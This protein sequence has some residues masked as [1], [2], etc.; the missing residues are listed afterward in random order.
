MK[1]TVESFDHLNNILLHPKN[2]THNLFELWSIFMI[3]SNYG[4]FAFLYKFYLVYDDKPP[5]RTIWL[6][7]IIN[8]KIK[9]TSS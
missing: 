9:H 5:D 1:Q 2:V 3:A 7:Q 6:S 4:M 8:R